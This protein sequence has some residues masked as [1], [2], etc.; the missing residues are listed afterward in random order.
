MLFGRVSLALLALLAC[1][2]M[3]L[4]FDFRD[5]VGHLGTLLNHLDRH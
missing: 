4:I 5:I 2:W 3:A 1:L